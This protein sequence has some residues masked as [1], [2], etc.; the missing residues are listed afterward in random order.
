MC[1]MRVI[2]IKLCICRRMID[3]WGKRSAAMM[4]FSM[5]A[6]NGR[7]ASILVNLMIFWDSKGREGKRWD[8][9]SLKS[10]AWWSMPSR[11]AFRMWGGFRNTG[12]STFPLFQHIPNLGLLEDEWLSFSFIQCSTPHHWHLTV[13]RLRSCRMRG[14][15]Y[16]CRAA[17]NWLASNELWDVKAHEKDQSRLTIVGR[18][19]PWWYTIMKI[20][21]RLVSWKKQHE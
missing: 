13:M 1:R 3:C 6:K 19:P 7:S 20:H 21:R 12:N 17:R 10:V 9:F 5:N 15:W 2:E 4:Q 8:I 11:S 14:S 16:G 18:A